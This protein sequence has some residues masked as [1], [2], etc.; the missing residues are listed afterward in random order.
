MLGLTA[1]TMV[2]LLVS[3]ELAPGTRYDEKIPTLRQVLGHEIGEEITSPEGI[4]IYLEALHAAAPERTRLVR[5][6][7]SWEKRPLHVLAVAAPEVMSRLE[8]IQ[9]GVRRLADPRDVAPP[10]LERLVREL[11]VVVWLAHAVHGNEISGPDAA[12]AEAYHLL[13]AQDSEDVETILQ[14]AVV[15]ID[16]LQNP[17]GRARFLL[18]TLQGR[19][20]IPD[21]EPASAEHDE[22]WPGGRSN[23]YLFDMNR[24]WFALTQPE[25]RGRVKLYQEWFPQVV[26]DLH[27]MGG[28]SS[29]YF[30]PPA[31]PPNPHITK[32]QHGWFDVFGK[33]NAARF[34][35]RGFAYFVREVFD[36]FYPGYGESWPLFHGAVGMTYEQA[37]ARGLVYRRR[38][39]TILTFRDGVV[40]QFTA[41]INTALVAA[42][43]RQ[44]LLGD[45]LEYRRSAVEEG[46]SGPVREYLIP[47][48]PDPSRSARLAW[49]LA[50]QGIEVSR[51]LEPVPLGQRTLPVGT[52]IV[53]LAQPAGRLVRNLLGSQ[54][55]L[56]EAFIREQDRRLGKRL[57]DEIYD[58]TAW[59]LPL[60]F[61]VECLEAERV[62]TV[63]ATAFDGQRAA[64]AGDL[65]EAQVGYLMPWGSGA[66]AAVAEALDTGLVARTAGRTFKLVGRD[67]AAGTVL[68][69]VS[70]NGEGL[71]ERLKALSASHEI[72]LV[73]VDSGW[74]E[75][76]ISLGSNEMRP[77]RP[78]KV[79]L[80][81][82]RPTRTLSAGWARWVLERRFGQPTTAVR[83][84][85]LGRVDLARYDVL[86]LPSGDYSEDLSGRLLGRI[87]E[88]MRSG[89]T[90]ITL[91]EA[92]RWAAR[93]KVG[94]LETHTE[95]R[96]GRPETEPDDEGE[97]KKARSDEPKPF[98]FE[99]AIE[100]EDER[101]RA[102]PGALLRVELDLEH[103]LSAGTD[104]EIQALVDGRRVFTPIKLDKGRN[105]GLYEQK[106][107]LLVSGLAWDEAQAGL[108]QKAFLIHQPMGAGHLV[109][110]AED[111]NY[112][113][114]TESTEL[115]FMNAVLLGPAH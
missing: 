29:Y 38:D 56:D 104:G 27:E 99:A 41:A 69:R 16:P 32:V 33:A 109:A 21:P 5:Y 96:D 70:D 52:Y 103:W 30:A 92:S 24:D 11:P 87:K 90:V 12:L 22:P 1:V 39:D 58:V 73:A 84:R 48:G 46:R 101:P 93:E 42:Q 81:W 2:A 18:T 91:G 61:D 63:P 86:V 114:F 19:A 14:R 3:P 102:T 4:A 57:R 79:L 110:F 94:L 36:S 37:S 44:K 98:D 82:D 80:A 64:G 95:L 28:E 23:H 17:D 71:G 7:E 105:V 75:E 60:L 67:F 15:L 115:L 50:A 89:G 51:A 113:G 77:M 111:P 85:S 72:E 62:T 68:F 66:A 74:V 78:P 34:D 107:R 53:S 76:G 49:L 100:P 112:R 88:W 97:K 55:P 43:N 8:E 20:A 6:A 25:T 65:A 35:E 40:R 13:A 83:V 9:A 108:A 54:V 106:D 45:F 10:E 47:P 59:S 31:Q 26:V